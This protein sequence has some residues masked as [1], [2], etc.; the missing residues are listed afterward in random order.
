MIGEDLVICCMETTVG[1]TIWT[2]ETVNI[3][4]GNRPD[5][6]RL[7]PKIC[8]FLLL[9]KSAVGIAAAHFSLNMSGPK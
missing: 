8:H 3:E 1:M 5:S 4:F 7:S 2:K 9:V 6:H